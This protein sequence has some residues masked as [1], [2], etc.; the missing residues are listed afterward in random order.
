M[1]YENN[2]YHNKIRI[3]STSTPMEIRQ[4]MGNPVYAINDS[5]SHSLSYNTYILSHNQPGFESSE[6]YFY[7]N[8][9]ADAFVH[10][11]DDNTKTFKKIAHD[12]FPTKLDLFRYMIKY[13]ANTII[14]NDVMME[15][16]EFIKTNP[17]Y[18]I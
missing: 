1:I 5:W 15:I 8:Y 2:K 17:Q 7:N 13:Y 11:V 16:N 3:L 10:D 12:L 4:L 14:Q 18:F 6:L 9:F